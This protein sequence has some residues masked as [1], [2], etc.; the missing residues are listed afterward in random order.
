MSLP[1]SKLQTH[2]FI[3]VPFLFP[4][5]IGRNI[6]NVTSQNKQKNTRDIKYAITLMYPA[7][8]KYGLPKCMRSARDCSR[9]GR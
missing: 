5:A 7:L 8:C 4:S 2:V 1:K 6:A 9:Q 3:S